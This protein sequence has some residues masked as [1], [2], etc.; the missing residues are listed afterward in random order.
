MKTVFARLSRKTS[1]IFGK[2]LFGEVYC[3]GPV[4]HGGNY[5]TKR[6]GPDVARG[7]NTRDISLSRLIGG[8]ITLCVKL[9]GTR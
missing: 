4:R 8:N 6:L 3:R 1:L 9:N 5:L 7:I 2:I